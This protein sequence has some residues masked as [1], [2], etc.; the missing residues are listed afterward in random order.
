[1]RDVVRHHPRSASC[2]PTTTPTPTSPG[3]T[4]G[5]SS[6]RSRSSDFE[7]PTP[8]RSPTLIDQIAE[9]VPAIF[10]SE[11]FPSPVLEQIGKET[12]V[13]Y[14]DE[15]RDDDLPGEPGDA[16]H[17]WLGLM[18]FDYVT[19]TDGARRRRVG[20]RGVRGRERRPRHGGVPAMSRDRACR[21]A[22]ARRRHLRLRHDAGA[23]RRRPDDRAPASSSASSGRRARARRRCCGSCSA[24]SRPVA[25]H[26]STRRPGLRI[27]YVPQVETINWSFPVTVARVRADGAHQRPAAAVARARAERAEVGRRARRGSASAT[28]PTATSASSRAASSSGCSSPARCSASPTC[29][30]STSRRRASTCDPPRGP[31]PAR[32]PQRRRAGDRAHDPR[33]QRHRRAPAAP[34]LPQHA[35]DRRGRA[36]RGAH[37]GRSSS[38]PTARGWRCSSTPACRSCVDHYHRGATSSRCAATG[39]LMMRRA[40]A[41]VRVRVLPQRRSSSPRSP[42]RCAA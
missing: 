10:G 19:M 24:A 36:A 16:E 42:A 12:G 23:R 33:P 30:C 22:R 2:S 8:R 34:R 38:A 6:A 3:P 5:R 37:A 21:A 27:G 1:M 9:K 20:A 4:A 31:A 25:R 28:S 40:A 17:S 39:G 32:R 11:V 18:Q 7:E 13:E 26:R 14:V 15:L 35:G 41:T 29:C